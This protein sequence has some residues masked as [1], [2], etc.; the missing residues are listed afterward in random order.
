MDK[1]NNI[2]KTHKYTGRKEPCPECGSNI[3]A[4]CLSCEICNAKV[5]CFLCQE[6]EEKQ[7]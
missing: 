5:P 7:Y 1:N 2:C 3:K 4:N 6:A